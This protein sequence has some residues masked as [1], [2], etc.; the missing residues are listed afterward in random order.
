[1]VFSDARLS[2]RLRKQQNN[3]VFF[4][5]KTQNIAME[6]EAFKLV[7]TYCYIILQ[8]QNEINVFIFHSFKMQQNLA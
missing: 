7:F 3:N 5:K 8:T 2:P 4:L 1:M 6:K